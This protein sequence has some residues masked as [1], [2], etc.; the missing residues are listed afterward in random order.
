M[1]PIIFQ[2]NIFSI[3]SLWVFVAIALVVATYA[4]I[5]IGLSNGL[6]LQF[7]SENA[8][9][10]IVVAMIGA[11]LVAILVNWTT[12]FYE[13]SLDTFL[14]I[15]K[16]WD[17]G[18]SLWGAVIFG[19]G[20]LY[21]LCKKNEQDFWKWMD[22]LVPAFFIGV[23]ISAIGMFMDGSNYG[24]ETSLPWGVNFESPAIKFT[25]PI[26]P[27]Q[28]YMLL[29]TTSISTALLH[30]K[31]LKFFE[32]N[33]RIALTGIAAFSLIHFLQEFV[34]GD[35]V[36][37][38]MGIRFPMIVAAIVFISTLIFYFYKYNK[39]KSN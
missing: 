2:S 31:K 17:K 15:F 9:K 5:K 32:P 39:T 13:Y 24:N 28:I 35:D 26:H 33:G 16:L 37:K 20:M 23:A 38:V 30:L 14:Q 6:K 12:F 1:H 36:L 3:H 11:R 21:Y 18:L 25:V 7:L 8:F 29:Y 19:V 10:I 27:T 34:R 4:F 22:S